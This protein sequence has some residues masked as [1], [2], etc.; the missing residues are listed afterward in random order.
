MGRFLDIL[1]EEEMRKGEKKKEKTATRKGNNKND[2][3]PTERLGEA[4]LGCGGGGCCFGCGA[5][6]IVDADCGAGW[7]EA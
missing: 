7:G 3:M 2:R 6:C 5:G 1:I 4:A